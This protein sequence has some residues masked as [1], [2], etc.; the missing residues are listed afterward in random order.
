MLLTVSSFGHGFGGSLDQEVAD[1]TDVLAFF[2]Y[3]LGV[4]R[5]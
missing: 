5:K 1:I 4:N 3:E 2:T